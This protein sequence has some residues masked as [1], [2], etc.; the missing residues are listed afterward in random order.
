[1]PRVQLYPA[2]QLAQLT[3]LSTPGYTSPSRSW[4]QRSSP[5][6]HQLHLANVTA[7]N[8]HGGLLRRLLRCQGETRLERLPQGQGDQAVEKAPETFSPLAMQRM[9]SLMGHH[10]PRVEGGEVSLARPV[11]ASSNHP[12]ALRRSR[13]PSS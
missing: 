3:Q 12:Q 8:A 1:M 5:L 7:S 10:R 11:A 9:L 13:L 6:G 4:L 2:Q